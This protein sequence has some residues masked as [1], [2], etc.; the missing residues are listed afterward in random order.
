MSGRTG[1]KLEIRVINISIMQRA[2]GSLAHAI[3]T[4]SGMI[5]EGERK[6]YEGEGQTE[7]NPYLCQMA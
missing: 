2:V 7:L 4:P 6:A 1:G 3:H 5:V